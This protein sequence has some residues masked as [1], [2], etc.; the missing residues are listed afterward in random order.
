MRFLQQ[1]KNQIL[2]LLI[3]LFGAI[4]IPSLLIH[5][6]NIN[7]E[8][9]LKVENLNGSGYWIL[10]SPIHIKSNWSATASTYDWCSGLGTP[11]SP[12]VIENVTIDAQNSESCIY[13]QNTNDNFKIQNCTLTNSQASP[14]S[15]IRMDF[16]SNGQIINNNI[17][18]NNGRGINLFVANYMLVEDNHLMNNG[19][20]ITLSYSNDNTIIKNYIEDSDFYG[21]YLWD[22]DDNIISENEVK[23]NGWYAGGYHG[24]YITESSSHVDSINNT[25]I[26]NNVDNNRKSGIYINSCDNNT[27]FGNEI[28]NNINDGIYLDDSDDIN[29]I[30]NRI[31]GSGCITTQSSTNTKEEWNVCNYIS[32]PFII[33]ELGGGNFTWEQV[34]QFAWCSGDGSHSNPFNIEDLVIDAQSIGS[35][36]RIENSYTKYFIIQHSLLMNAQAIGGEAGIVLDHVHNG[37][38]SHISI[39]SNYAGIYL[40]Y[41][42]NILIN[43][44]GLDGNT[45]QGIVL[46]QSKQN[47]II[48]N[49]QSSSLYYGLMLNSGSDNNTVSGNTFESN[50]GAA[51]HG[52]GI[53]I[54][55][56][57]DNKII[58]NTLIDNDKG[59]RIEDNSHDNVV[60]QNIIENNT[61]YG[62]LVIADP[63]IS[64]DNQFYLNSFSNPSAQNAYDNGTNTT[65]DNGSIGNY[66]SDYSGLD[67]D[68]D[69]IGDTAHSL[70]G[71]G[72]GIDHFPI[73]DDGDDIVPIITIITPL[74]N[75]KYNTTAPSYKITIIELN[76][77][78]YYYVISGSTGDSTRIIYSLSGIVEQSLWDL[79]PAGTYTLTVHANDTAGN[80]ASA[81]VTIIKENLSPT[82]PPPPPPAIPFGNFYL[83]IGICSV[84]LLMVSA[85]Y[86][87]KKEH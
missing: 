15:A 39:E 84:I 25:I 4:S 8:N 82:P 76:L 54:L 40:S 3:L 57:E 85:R 34:S 30:G 28:N 67:A 68:D 11:Q 70:P 27:I 79:L 48:D 64:H 78:T 42:K 6:N 69:G 5:S 45:G 55:N 20:G 81:N 62:A 26:H 50:T 80:S 51:T 31:H 22:S 33:D 49:G 86:K 9:S 66:W 12:Y 53:R 52:D 16:V 43:N 14:H 1:N 41:S 77:D 65:W 38:L 21:I 13:I 74:N 24:I 60:S 32:D 72:S 56:S 46:F 75:S 2:L 29:I 17:T 87:I 19:Y 44:N 7:N 23:H 63:R 35:C 61:V 71:T 58:N 47:Q 10:P 83:L 36:I 73:W 18:N 59:I 37:T